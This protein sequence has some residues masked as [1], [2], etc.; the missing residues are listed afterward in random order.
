[1][2][3]FLKYLIFWSPFKINSRWE[4]LDYKW[5]SENI[6]IPE[7][8][9]WVKII[10]IWNWAFYRKGISNIILPK[11]LKEIWSFA[12][13]GNNIKNLIIPDSVESIWDEAFEENIIENVTIWKNVRD[14]DCFAFCGNN[15]KNLYLPKNIKVWYWAFIKKE[16]VEKYYEPYNLPYKYN[17]YYRDFSKELNNNDR[18]ILSNSDY[19]AFSICYYNKNH[20]YYNDEDYYNYYRDYFSKKQDAYLD[21]HYYYDKEKEDELD[22][23]FKDPPYDFIDDDGWKYIRKKIYAL[24]DEVENIYYI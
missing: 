19:S 1:M 21:L 16:N 8:I 12:F 14:I 9:W 18:I 5:R 7:E 20:I 22:K 11:T 6:I 23:K 13:C 2:Y 4:I 15:I 10:Y 17:F 3:S 24:E